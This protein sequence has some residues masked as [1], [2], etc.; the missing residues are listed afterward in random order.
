MILQEWS[1]FR[2]WPRHII[3]NRLKYGWTVER[4]LTEEP[5]LLGPR[6]RPPVPQEPSAGMTGIETAT[7]ADNLPQ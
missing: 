5:V 3:S 4:A 1:E 2:G 7:P 6:R